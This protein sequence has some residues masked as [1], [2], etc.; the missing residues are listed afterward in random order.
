[1]RITLSVLLFIFFGSLF[2]QKYKSNETYT[3]S[4]LIRRY[5]EFDDNS[6]K[7]KLIEVGRSDI[8][9]PIHVFVIN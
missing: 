3:Y 4:E 5:K 8:G 7:G 9:K 6:S 1:M 2:A